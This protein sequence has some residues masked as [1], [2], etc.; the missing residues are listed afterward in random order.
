M[1]SSLPKPFGTSLLM[2]ALKKIKKSNF[3]IFHIFH[4][5]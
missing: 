4:L 2:L 1:F 5:S 3:E